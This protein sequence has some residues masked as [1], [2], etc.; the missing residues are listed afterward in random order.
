MVVQWLRLRVVNAESPGSIPGQ[1]PR[2][3]I[4]LQRSK[5]MHATSKTWC[6][7]INNKYLNNYKKERPSSPRRELQCSRRLT[8][9]PLA[10]GCTWSR[11]GRG[12]SPGHRSPVSPHTTLLLTGQMAWGHREKLKA[13]LPAG[14]VMGLRGKHSLWSAKIKNHKI[15]KQRSKM[16]VLLLNTSMTWDNTTIVN[17]E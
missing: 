13:F 2:S 10:S 3:H 8:C 12:S 7:Q 5:I 16:L 4:L 17:C 6:S 15:Q 11:A 14:H 9:I 1:G